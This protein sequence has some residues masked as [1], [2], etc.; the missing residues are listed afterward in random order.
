MKKEFSIMTPK[1]IHILN[2]QVMYNHFKETK[3]LDQ[4]LM[5]PFNEAMCYGK[6]CDDLFSKKFADIRAKVHHVTP[7]Q[8]SEITLK[9][10]QPLLN[11]EFTHITLWFDADMFC[12]INLLTILAW[13]DRTE[14][15]DDID[16]HIVDDKFEPVSQFSLKAKGF[17]TIYQ[18]VLIH[19]SQPQYTL[20]APL[21]QGVDLYLS[22]PNSDSELMQYIQKHKDVPEKELVTALMNRF[23]DYGLGDTQYF[24]IIKSHRA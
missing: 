14:Y 13:L 12:Q 22:Y 15:K 2:G 18:Q 19:K 21:K 11:K 9:P 8:Y 4:E 16:I 24:E 10:L 7:K 5:I 17:Y 1:T 3:F 23:R 6:T 20:P